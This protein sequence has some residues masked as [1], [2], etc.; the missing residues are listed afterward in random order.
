MT[1]GLFDDSKKTQYIDSAIMQHMQ[2][3]TIRYLSLSS[4]AMSRIHLITT[5]EVDRIY[6]KVSKIGR[7]GFYYGQES[8]YNDLEKFAENTNRNN[9]QNQNKKLFYLP[10]CDKKDHEAIENDEQ[11]LQLYFE[12][13]KNKKNPDV[14]IELMELS[15]SKSRYCFASATRTTKI[16]HSF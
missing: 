2:K 10:K 6:K 7:G 13:S 1:K 8:L 4:L 3:K 15:L 9:L 12:Y 11:R 14:P 16:F 5:E